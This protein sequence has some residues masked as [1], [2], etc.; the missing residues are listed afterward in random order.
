VV[1]LREPASNA[2]AAQ[3]NTA[4]DPVAESASNVR[5]VGYNDLQGRTALV[6]TTK[7]DP[8]NGNW[9]YIGHHDAFHDGKPVLNP[10]TGKMEFNGTSILDITDPAKPKY[11]W[12]IPNPTNR[13]SRSTSVVHDYKF[14]GSGKD[15]LI[16]NSEALTQGETG[17]DLK[18]EIWDVTTRNTDPSKITKV[19]EI[20]GTPPNSCGPGCGGKF[21]QRAH[22]GWWSQDTGYFY[23]ASG[24]P[25]FRNIIVQIFDLKN[26]KEPRLVGRAWI[27]GLRDGEPGYEG[28][29]SHHP[30][31]DE[32]NKRL[33]VGY[34][35]AGGQAASFDISDPAHPK[36]VWEIDMNPPFRGPHTVSPIKY[37]TVP[38]FGKSALPRTYA[39]IVDE[40]GGGADM[41]PCTSGVRTGAYML[42]IT[43]ETKP[44]VVSVF[45]VPVGNFCDKGGRFG[46]HQSAE[47]VNGRIN[48]FTDKT[49]WL[50][51]FNAGIRVLDLSDPYN[52]KELGHYIP[53]TTKN[54]YPISKGQPVAIQINDVDI[55]HRGLAY[56]VDRAGAGLFVLEYTGSK[57]RQMTTAY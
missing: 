20:T 7:S 52:M 8:A 25:G 14:D 5:L 41:K 26:P 1:S 4:A 16:R 36:L 40:A 38:N 55:D 31:V 50:A 56:A 54:S 32:D 22:K 12:H 42:D 13:N 57:P 24:E 47:T 34:R 11:V 28:Q 29:Y 21:K 3:R 48:R 19:G 2:V 33:Y 43:A 15:Y 37:D 51:Y 46:P 30:I 35:N 44:M 9:V 53:K 18:Y 39:F 27:P 45:Q 17:E 6:T 23:A 10:L 49:A